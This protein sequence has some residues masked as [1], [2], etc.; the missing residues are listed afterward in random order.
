MSPGD[1]NQPHAGSLEK[2]LQ[3]EEAEASRSD[4]ADAQSIRIRGG[5]IGGHVGEDASASSH[6]NRF[7]PVLKSGET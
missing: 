4:R 7:L 1:G 6:A 3:G 5:G 2:L